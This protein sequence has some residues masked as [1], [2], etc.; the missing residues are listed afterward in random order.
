MDFTN[1]LKGV[2]TQVLL[3]AL[4]EDGGYRIIP[5]GI[6]EVIRELAVLRKEEYAALKLPNI[7]R[8]LPDFFVTDKALKK[9]WLVEVKY[10]KNWNDQTRVYLGRQI[11]EQVRDWAPLYLIV[12]L[13]SPGKPNRKLPSSWMGLLCLSMID[14]EIFALDQNGEPCAKW[15]KI[16]W[17]SFRRVQDIF[18]NIGKKEKWEQQTLQKVRVLLLQLKALD[19]FE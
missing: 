16:S 7:L 18:P 9:S 11:R 19:V 15:S 5:L 12:F 14:G 1:R 2:V 8:Q 13:G 6:E 4:L 3:R 17:K 10:R